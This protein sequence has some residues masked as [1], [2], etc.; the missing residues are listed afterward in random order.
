[1]KNDSTRHLIQSISEYLGL[2]ITNQQVTKIDNFISKRIKELKI[3]SLSEYM[4]FLSNQSS[5]QFAAENALL[6]DQLT[7]NETFFFRDIGQINLLKQTILPRLLELNRDT[8]RLRIW[9]AGCSSGEEAYTIAM[10]LDELGVDW[11]RW[12]IDIFGTDINTKALAKANKATYGEW[13]FRQVSTE[14]KFRFFNQLDRVY[15]VKS[16]IKSRVQFFFVNLASDNFQDACQ[17]LLD[18]D[19]IV[20]RNVFIYMKAAQSSKIADKLTASLIP[21]GYLMTGHNELYAHH[22]GELRTHIFE[23]SIIYQRISV[24]FQLTTTEESAPDRVKTAVNVTHHQTSTPSTI[25]NPQPTANTKHTH[26][27]S[28]IPKDEANMKTAWKYANQG[29][30]AEA[31]RICESLIAHNPLDYQAY[32]LQAL[33]LQEQGLLDNAIKLLQKVIYLKPN[34]VS[35]L[36]ELGDIYFHQRQFAEAARNWNNALCVLEREPKD[37]TT[38]MFADATIE[39]MLQFVRKK[40]SSMPS[41]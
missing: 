20:C 35:A 8:K 6:I 19:L 25:S 40:I 12:R 1:M 33:L 14:R 23:S 15:E 37:A 29:K 31:S 9:S 39:D 36:I 30:S 21:G 26:P 34:H 11:N 16:H 13:S 17:N 2:T 24:E 4:D 38:P 7:T 3:G 5:D 41:I 28:S 18:F 32:Y 10:L 27:Q 22:L